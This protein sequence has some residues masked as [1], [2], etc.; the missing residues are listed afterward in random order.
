MNNLKSIE[1]HQQMMLYKKDSAISVKKNMYPISKGGGGW[2][3]CREQIIYFNSACWRATFL[4][5]I[6]CLYRTVLEVNYLFHAR[7]YLLKKI[8]HP[9]PWRF[10]DAR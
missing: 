5:F 4:K 8:P 2:S 1:D 3:C 6:G 9:H 7:N 10:N